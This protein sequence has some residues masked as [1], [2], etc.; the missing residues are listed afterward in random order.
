MVKAKKAKKKQLVAKPAALLDDLKAVALK[1][2]CEGNIYSGGEHAGTHIGVP[3]PALALEYLFNS[4]VLYVGAVYG[5]AGPPQSYKSNLALELGKLLVDMGSVNAIAETEGGKISP[6]VLENIYGDKIDS[7]QLNCVR[8]VEAAQKYL[9]TAF[10]WYMKK[11][12]KRNQL[13]AGFVDSINGANSMEK[14]ETIAKQ[15][16]GGRSFPIEAMLWSQWLQ[17]RSNKLAGWPAVLFLVNHE[18]QDINDPKRKRHPGGDAQE[19]FSTIYMRVTR[20]K[21]NESAELVINQLKIQT[22]KH[23]FGLPRRAITVPFV[24]DK[25]KMPPKLY[26]DWGHATAQLLLD[27]KSLVGS[28]VDVT[29]STESMTAATRTFNCKTLGLTEVSGAALG[30]AVQANPELMKQLRQVLYVRT[31]AVWNGIMPASSTSVSHEPVAVDGGDSDDG[32]TPM[33]GPEDLT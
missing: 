23:S 9:T 2:K 31:E 33:S 10:E 32:E 1:S 30:A 21:T 3:L 20:E 24:V 5:L 28:I 19:F 12:P 25:T 15:G 6:T 13:F 11:W 26:F 17:D 4:T 14:H 16:Y 22:I 29:S 7:V 18:K 8:S 27:Q